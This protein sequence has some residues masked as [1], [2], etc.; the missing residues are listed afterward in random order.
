MSAY[1]VAPADLLAEHGRTF[2]ERAGITVRDKPMPLFQ[3]AVLTQ[4]S[5]TRISADVAA[6]AAR[7]LF[8]AG[9]RTPEQLRASTWQQRVAA[10]GRGGYRRYDESTADRLAELAE[11]VDDEVGGDLRRWRPGS[12]EE[13]PALEA[14]LQ[15]LPRIGPTGAAIFCR[16][17]QAVWPEVRPYFDARCRRAARDL[18]YPAEPEALA[19]L[20]PPDRLAA[21]SA[22]LV[23]WALGAPG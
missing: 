14:A 16:E 11:A 13:V 18:G 9:W 17:V 7:E 3:L 12:R 15:R 22:A 10:L 6:R 21:F 2:A 8:R 23:R 1:R 20:V 19:A 5:S 4:L